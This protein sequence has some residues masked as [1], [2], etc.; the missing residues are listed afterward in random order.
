MAN[1]VPSRT[2]CRLEGTKYVVTNPTPGTGLATI[3]ALVAYDQTKAFLTLRNTDVLAGGKSIVPDYLKLINTA[4]GTAGAST[5]LTVTLD[6]DE[7]NTK[8]T[9]GGSILA[10]VGGA[11]GARA[12][13]GREGGVG[14]AEVHAGALVSVAGPASRIVS[15]S[16]FRTVIPVVGDEYVLVFGVDEKDISNPTLNGA[17]PGKFLEF[18]PEVEI[19][20]H[21][22][23]ACHLWLPSQSAASSW[24]VELA[25]WELVA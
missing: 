1:V 15:N 11:P 23:M 3:A 21:W 24:E 5:H 25:Y 4:A 6:T 16:I 2:R 17:V 7:P 8:W 19:P 10:G 9:S 22:V 12:V 20:P 13:S 18:A 14:I